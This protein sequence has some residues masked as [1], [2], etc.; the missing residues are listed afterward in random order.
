MTAAVPIPDAPGVQTG[1]ESG[2]E[3]EAGLSAAFAKTLA[4]MPFIKRAP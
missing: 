1:C 2:L 3:A 4:P